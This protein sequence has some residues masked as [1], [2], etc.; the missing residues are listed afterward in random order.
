MHNMHTWWYGN[1][2][3][4]NTILYSS[5]CPKLDALKLVEVAGD[6]ADP[7]R[8][9]A[10]GVAD[11]GLVVLRMNELHQPVFGGVAGGLDHFALIEAPSRR[12]KRRL[13]Q[14]RERDAGKQV[15]VR[16]QSVFRRDHVDDDGLRGVVLCAVFT[17]MS[18]Q[19]TS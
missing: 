16:W 18:E 8:A 7:H 11:A 4:E 12:R 9:Q 14:L 3:I 10:T 19:S 17:S 15:S 1:Q 5:K 13:R 6:D 2:T